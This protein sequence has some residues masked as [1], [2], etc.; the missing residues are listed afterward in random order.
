MKQLNEKELKQIDDWY[1]DIVQDLDQSNLDH[2]DK[3]VKMSKEY[4]SHGMKDINQQ[5]KITKELVKL[6]YYEKR[7][8]EVIRD[9]SKELSKLLSPKAEK[10]EIAKKVENFYHYVD[11]IISKE[12][13]EMGEYEYKIKNTILTDR[14]EKKQSDVSD[15]KTG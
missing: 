1:E 15:T 2:L 14:P 5:K 12:W 10:E 13:S 3:L 4:C 11:S 7:H 8:I 9:L 6:R